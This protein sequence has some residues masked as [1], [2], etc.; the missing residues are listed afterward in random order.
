MSE[1][2]GFASFRF[3]V[4]SK[5][6]A[7]ATKRRGGHVL[8]IEDDAELVSA[9]CRTL[10]PAGYEVSVAFDGSAGYFTAVGRRPDVIILD[11]D[12][13]GFAG[14]HMLELLT[15]SPDTANTPVLAITTDPDFDRRNGGI[16]EVLQ[17]PFQPSD[18]LGHVDRMT[19]GP[20]KPRRFLR[21]TTPAA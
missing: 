4:P 6:N 11:L 9:T 5:P 20:K 19:R 10:R 16:V 2:G 13:P 14:R 8:I 18:L 21:A 3:L 12:L 1:R 7:R 15:S 17:K